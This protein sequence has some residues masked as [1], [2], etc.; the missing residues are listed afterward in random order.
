MFTCVRAPPWT[1]S[2]SDWTES[3]K[4]HGLSNCSEPNFLL[5]G[6]IR[7]ENGGLEDYIDRLEGAMCCSA[8]LEYKDDDLKCR[9][10]LYSNSTGNN[11]HFDCYY[12]TFLRGFYRQ[13]SLPATFDAITKGQCCKHRSGPSSYR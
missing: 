10:S 5:N 8:P 9:N 2:T 11:L 13:G 3:I 12:G 1:C 7:G 4:T 6:L